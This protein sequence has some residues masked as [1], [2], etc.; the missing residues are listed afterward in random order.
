M[1][2]NVIDGKISG[3]YGKSQT[4]LNG[5]MIDESPTSGMSGGWSAEDKEKIVLSATLC[6]VVGIM[7][8]MF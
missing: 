7:Q 1:V 6:L 3:Q 5:S 2:G 8:V 4:N